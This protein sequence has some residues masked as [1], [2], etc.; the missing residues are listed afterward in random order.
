MSKALG[1]YM[2]I[3]IIN[4]YATG[5]TGTI[6]S[7]I[8]KYAQQKGHSVRFFYGRVKQNDSGWEFIGENRFNLFLSNGFAY[9]TG[10]IGSYHISSTKRLIKELELYQ[11]DVIH[12]HNIHGNYLNFH[13]LFNYFKTFKGKVVI[14]AH[15][16]FLL[17][18]RCALCV[19]DKWK[20]GC[21]KC[22]YLKA[23]PHAFI[24]R[25]TKLQRRKIE[26]LKS[27]NNLTV[28]VP[29]QWLKNLFE[30]SKI[31]SVDCRCIRNGLSEPNEEP[32][33][34]SSLVVE[35]KINILFAAF[36]WNVDKGA[37][38]IK[39]LSNKIDN[40]KYNIIVTG[41][42]KSNLHWFDSN[43]STT[44]LLKRGQLFYLLKHVDL[45]ANPTFKDNLPTILIESLK[46]GT[47]AITFN[48]GGCKEI[49]NN[50]CGLLLDNKNSDSLLNAINEFDFTKATKENCLKQASLFSKE[51][52]AE[53]YLALYEEGKGK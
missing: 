9:L 34:I 29:S 12:L 13:M 37:E 20:S 41:V 4:T 31:N 50:T 33:D 28:V 26:M 5:S 1:V 21:N 52:M 32:F 45:F 30:L 6:A 22:K 53:E 15:D 14:T 51:K 49:I 18:G 40:N 36:T 23:Y 44:G 24:D 16:E 2:K 39:E 42:N 17:T 35:G 48:T 38:V 27:I 46:A 43:C 19:C 7:L 25:S 10:R 47:P 11:P 3:A 8:G